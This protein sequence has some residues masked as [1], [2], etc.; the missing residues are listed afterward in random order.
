MRRIRL[1]V[2]KAAHP[3]SDSGFVAPQFRSV[4]KPEVLSAEEA[5]SPVAAHDRSVR[6]G[7]IK[8]VAVELKRR[9]RWWQIWRKGMKD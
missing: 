9:K 1:K 8:T 2:Q 5:A 7:F 3:T 4:Q 6:R